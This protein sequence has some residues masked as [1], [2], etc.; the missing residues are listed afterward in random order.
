MMTI[1]KP[2]S[3]KT[4]LNP[5]GE[6]QLING[7]DFRVIIDTAV[8]YA[9]ARLEMARNPVGVEQIFGRHYLNAIP[10]GKAHAC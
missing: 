3:F 2:V 9:P 6:F 7:G 5:E 8:G 10:V 4:P 1:F